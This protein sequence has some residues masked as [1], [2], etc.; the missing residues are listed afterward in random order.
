MLN[1]LEVGTR[2]P[3]H[4]HLMTSE[5]VVAWRGAWSGYFMMRCLAWI[6]EALCMMARLLR[7]RLSLWR[8]PGLG[9]VPGTACLVSRC[10]RGL[11]TQLRC[12]RLLL[13]LR[14]RMGLMGGD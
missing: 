2:V 14:L 3:I 8:L 13:F 5:T 9:F 11:G 10:L 1:A 6:P 4:R 12:M 7:T